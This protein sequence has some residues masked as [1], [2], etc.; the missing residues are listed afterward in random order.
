MIHV[1]DWLF[2][3]KTLLHVGRFSLK[4]HQCL[5]L[6][7]LSSC[8]KVFLQY[9][10]LT[11]PFFALQFHLNS[12]LSHLQ[13]IEW[14]RSSTALLLYLVSRIWLHFFPPK[15]K[16]WHL[17]TLLAIQIFW[18]SFV[19]GASQWYRAVK[20][21][22]SCLIKKEFSLRHEL[23]WKEVCM[24]HNFDRKWASLSHRSAW[25]QSSTCRP[26]RLRDGL[27]WIHPQ[28]TQNC[29][30]LQREVCVC[31][32]GMNVLSKSPDYMSSSVEREQSDFRY[33]TIYWHL[34]SVLIWVNR[35]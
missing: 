12:F 16:K 19:T 17:C 9:I 31:V 34:R 26:L 5:Y 15:I 6:M 33:L 3:I 11:P 24:K 2:S 13:N 1:L 35:Q 25:S 7:S 21:V 27:G 4:P 22:K 8:F 14:L 32:C 10:C 18:K 23:D 30:L 20:S 28:G 29:I